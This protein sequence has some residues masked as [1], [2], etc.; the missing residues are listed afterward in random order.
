[1]GERQYSRE[2]MQAILARALE[3]Q[4]RTDGD[5]YRHAQ[6]METAQELG[7]SPAEVEAAIADVGRVAERDRAV[8]ALVRDRQRGFRGHLVAYVAVNL[9]LWGV[10]L[11]TAAMGVNT[12]T[13]WHWI[14]AAAWGIGVMAHA[15][16]VFGRDPE[17]LAQDAQRRLERRARKARQREMQ[18]KI[19]TAVTEA[20]TTSADALSRLLK[21]DDHDR[22]R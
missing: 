11:A 14:V 3:R 8:A 4:G 22:R 16:R 10:D 9:G 12:Q 18:R 15:W 20:V 5:G 13:G 6:L 19:E 21:P 7:L 1:M 17:A 2:E